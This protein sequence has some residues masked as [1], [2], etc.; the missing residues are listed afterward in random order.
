MKI[1]TE[2]IVKIIAVAFCPLKSDLIANVF[3]NSA[4]SESISPGRYVNQPNDN[5]KTTKVIAPWASPEDS[6]MV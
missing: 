3:K 4:T 1:K 6:V 2:K 5:R